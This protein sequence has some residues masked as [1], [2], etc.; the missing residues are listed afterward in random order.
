M[1]D[2][3]YIMLLKNIRIYNSLSCLSFM[4]LRANKRARFSGGCA[5]IHVRAS[6]S[7]VSLALELAAKGLVLW[8]RDVSVCICVWPCFRLSLRLDFS[9]FSLAKYLS[10]YVLWNAMV[11]ITHSKVLCLFVCL[12]A[13]L[14]ACLFV[15]LKSINY[16]KTR[17]Q[18]ESLFRFAAIKP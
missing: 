12:F 6:L 10:E 1:P 3:L 2:I 13:G 14:L 11:G 7:A 17:C 9:S 18:S 16:I 4:G 5:Q 8:T 15:F